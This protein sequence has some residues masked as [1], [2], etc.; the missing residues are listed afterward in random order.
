MGA[1]K[2]SAG[3]EK[4]KGSKKK[5]AEL[6]AS[7]PSGVAE[8]ESALALPSS[9]KAAT[10]KRT[11]PYR[12]DLEEQVRRIIEMK[13]GHIDRVLLSTKTN[14]GGQTVYEFIRDAVLA[15]KPQNGRLSTQFWTQFH[16]S[17]DLTWDISADLP[18]PTD[19]DAESV[20]EE[21]LEA[22]ALARSRN[23]AERNPG[24]LCHYLEHCGTLTPAALYGVLNGIQPGPTLGVAHARRLQLSCLKYCARTAPVPSS[25]E[26]VVGPRPCFLLDC[27]AY[28]KGANDPFVATPSTP[29]TRSKRYS[30]AILV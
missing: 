21:L 24:L 29:S 9:G 4:A 14:K 25:L 1:G 5:S 13:L 20:E 12:R 10:P 11:Q 6:G 19:E 23:L 18:E 3:K 28:S 30:Q 7:A 17:F 15:S 16:A 22:M 8:S 2:K 27:I 26:D